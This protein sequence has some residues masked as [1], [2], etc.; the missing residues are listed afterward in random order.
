MAKNNN[1][2]DFI[3]DLGDTIRRKKGT[4]AKINP[5]NFSS[6][7]ESIQTGSDPVLQSK[8]VTPSTSQ[9]KV[10]PDAGYDGLSDVTVNAVTNN[11]DVNIA[12][13]NIKKGVSILGVTGTLEEG[14]AP[15]GT[16][17]IKEN[18][19]HNVANYEFAEVSVKNTAKAILGKWNVEGGYYFEFDTN[20]IAKFGFGTQTSSGTYT[21]NDVT[22]SINIPDADMFGDFVYD[23]DTDTLTINDGEQLVLTR[24]VDIREKDVIGKW[25]NPDGVILLELKPNGVG[26]YMSNY[27]C[28]YVII[29]NTVSVE[30]TGQTISL[31]Y[32]EASDILISVLE[33]VALTRVQ[34][35]ANLI[36]KEVT[37][38]GTYK[39]SD[40]GADGYSEVVVN[41]AGSGG[42][43][44]FADATIEEIQQIG[45]E[46]SDKGMT[47][48]EVKSK[49]GWKIGDTKDITLTTGEVIQMRIIGFNHDTLSDGSGKAG[50][51]LEMVDCLN[52]KYTMQAGF[53]N[54]MD[55]WGGWNFTLYQI[56]T[57]KSTLPQEWQNIIRQ[58]DKKYANGGGTNF[59]AVKTTS[60]DL[61]I[62]S[63]I[64]L[65]GSVTKAQ[66]GADEGS[67]YEYWN[68]KS[69]IDRIKKVRSSNNMWALRSCYANSSNSVVTVKDDG[70]INGAGMTYN[71][72]I[73]FAFCVGSAKDIPV[74]GLPIE[75]TT[76][77][78]MTN[79]LV[80]D[81]L[82]KVYK[83]TGTS[84]TYDNNAI[85]IIEEI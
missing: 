35:T 44:P 27:D 20:G 21:V 13:G 73:S 84:D 66:N 75:A 48:E 82:G 83:F 69:D 54:N 32:D 78:E 53:A 18:G 2:Q 46:I 9:Q 74:A 57:I 31:L 63:E 4:S 39:A 64:E 71:V 76:D 67:V 10:Q 16:L 17:E 52:T 25:K 28:T 81:N 3:Q 50:I 47:S 36:T 70:Q 72:G 30:V 55:G 14:I 22:V 23:E 43:T 51:T 8:S 24:L 61:F 12:A 80:E 29:G 19:R 33:G 6:E 11:I 65:T 40:D 34:Q 42:A 15:T 56:P 45:N 62:L 41:V 26:T 77:Q 37:E 60:N 58:V 79:A 85:Y 1:I 68:G 38:N 7:I 59:T 49:Y 5:Q